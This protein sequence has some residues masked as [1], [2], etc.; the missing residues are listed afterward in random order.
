MV[1]SNDVVVA[2]S[3][4]TFAEIKTAGGSTFGTALDSTSQQWHGMVS[5][6]FTMP[7][8]IRAGIYKINLDSSYTYTLDSIW[9]GWVAQHD[10]MTYQT[11]ANESFPTDLTQA[12][13][14]LTY[15]IYSW[16]KLTD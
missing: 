1:D 8:N 5:F 11:Y 14:P 15:E 13:V 6:I 7:A 12:E 2:S 3:S 16:K 10:N 9:V 4:Q